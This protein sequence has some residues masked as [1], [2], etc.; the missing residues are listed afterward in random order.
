MQAKKR[1]I[2]QRLNIEYLYTELNILYE[3][4]MNHLNIFN[5]TQTFCKSC[6]IWKDKLLLK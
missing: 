6:L 2:Q 4:K 3:V 5:F 1:Y